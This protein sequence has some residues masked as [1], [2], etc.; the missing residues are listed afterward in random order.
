MNLNSKGRRDKVLTH[1][2]GAHVAQ[3]ELMKEFFLNGD[4]SSD[5]LTSNPDNKRL[6]LNE[7]GFCLDHLGLLGAAVD[8]YLRGLEITTAMNDGIN[9]S[10]ICSNIASLYVSLGNLSE[11]ERFTR[12]A[13]EFIESMNRVADFRTV[14]ENKLYL[15][16]NEY[17]FLGWVYH[18]RG[19]LEQADIFFN[20]AEGELRSVSRG[21]ISCLTS[22]SAI[23]HAEHL[24]R[25]GNLTRAKEIAEVNFKDLQDYVD[26]VVIS[27]CI[28]GRIAHDLRDSDTAMQHY[29]KAVMIAR[30]ASDRKIL[31]EALLVRGQQAAKQGDIAVASS[32]LS[33]ALDYA[34][35]SGYRVFEISI[36]VGLA[37][38]YLASGELVQAK[39]EVK[40]AKDMSRE[41]GFYWG[42]V[43]SEEVLKQINK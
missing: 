32:D 34:V 29:H 6:I 30:Q 39:N 10:I 8:F 40:Q 25:T 36:R 5:P 35:S 24:R 18:L 41:T 22:L 2:L 43:D 37:W 14:I 19:D 7:I 15:E 11:G 28:L 13:I 21:Q 42:K 9:S 20:H 16:I 23:F 26:E 4:L 27:H 17:A 3:L 31:I 12:M 38:M 33:E 1:C